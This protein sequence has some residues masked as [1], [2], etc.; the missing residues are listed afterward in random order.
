MAT[1]LFLRVATLLPAASSTLSQRLRRIWLP[2]RAERGEIDHEGAGRSWDP[3]WISRVVC[4]IA[5]MFSAGIVY[6]S[7]LVYTWMCL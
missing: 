6:C 1:S 4:R 7:M 3:C 2:L 5:S